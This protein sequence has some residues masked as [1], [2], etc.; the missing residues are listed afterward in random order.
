MTDKPNPETDV[1][2]ESLK[3]DIKGYF[4]N[5]E[6]MHDRSSSYDA[7]RDTMIRHEN[8]LRKAVGLTIV[9]VQSR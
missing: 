9:A 1:T 5:R 6:A 2:I 3:A 7:H 4:E 8:R